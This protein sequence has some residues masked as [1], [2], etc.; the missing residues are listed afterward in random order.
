MFIHD[1]AAFGGGLKKNSRHDGSRKE[2]IV[3]RDYTIVR[4]LCDRLNGA[5]G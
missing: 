5:L 2:C 1:V 3:V 4:V